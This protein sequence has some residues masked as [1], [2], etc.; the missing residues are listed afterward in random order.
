MRVGPWEVRKGGGDSDQLTD[1]LGGILT[2]GTWLIGAGAEDASV[3]CQ[4]G[5]GLSGAGGMAQERGQSGMWLAA[6]EVPGMQMG[7]TLWKAYEWRWVVF[8]ALFNPH[9]LPEISAGYCVTLH[10]LCG[11]QTAAGLDTPVLS[12]PV[13]LK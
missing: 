2:L 12:V 3:G 5:C 8:H 11:C 13:V 7:P 9:K 6:V 10:F 4:P 1:W